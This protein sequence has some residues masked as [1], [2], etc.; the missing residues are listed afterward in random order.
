MK[1]RWTLP[2]SVYWF[3][4]STL[5]ASL[6]LTACGESGTATTGAT[7]RAA[8]GATTAAAANVTTGATTVAGATPGK[9]PPNALPADTKGEITIAIW[10]NIQKY[11]KQGAAANTAYGPAYEA[12]KEWNTLHP[13]VKINWVSI[14]TATGNAPNDY[15]RTQLVA[16]TLADLVMS[17]PKTAVH[18]E[19]LD[20]VYDWKADLSK[21]NPYGS[22][23]TWLEELPS[24]LRYQ[25]QQDN[26]AIV[27]TGK[28]PYIGNISP[29][30][31]G[32]AA[33]VYYNKDMFAKAG[34]TKTPKTWV[35]LL[36]TSKKLKE[37]GFTP[38]YANV[39]AGPTVQV[40]HE[41]IMD[42]LF[43]NTWNDVRK[44]WGVTGACSYETDEARK[45][46]ISMNDERLSWAISKGLFKA[47]DPR[48]LEVAK[49][50]KEFTPY[51]NKD[52][53]A[54]SNQDG[55]SEFVN[56]RTAMYMSGSWDLQNMS[57]DTTR[58][59]QF[60]TFYMPKVTAESSQFANNNPISRGGS[61]Q[62]YGDGNAFFMPKTVESKG[63]NLA[64]ARDIVQYIVN[65]PQNEKYCATLFMP[66]IPEGKKMEDVV[67]DPVKLD[68]MRGFVE[69]LA[70]A[71]TQ[72]A[73]WF[74]GPLA[75]T[76][77]RLFQQYAT[78][79]ISLEEFGKQYQ[80]EMERWAKQNI[81][82]NSNTWKVDAWPEIPKS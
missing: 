32:N 7:T 12:I 62:G 25:P 65:K 31:K 56:K 46:C 5:L 3:V 66:C 16:G 2:K 38:Y 42:D 67:K 20:L 63:N 64:I 71:T 60:A 77:L 51:W 6:L 68:Q 73:A 19:N 10:D 22:A 36:D 52:W 49:L 81:T 37:A 55:F 44:A 50:V 30:N 27:A 24:A 70:L 79:R 47:T 26:P 4:L 33:T 21:P 1:L 43:S 13:N 23:A 78:D 18:Q 75:D 48:F 61:V 45:N 35:E 82:K 39:T 40:L 59:F 17:F 53:L 74:V 8:I 28:V 57:T 72:N 58:D 11:E 76:Y 9:L 14:P 69:P 80:T 41:R 29:G 34:I 15:L 54:P